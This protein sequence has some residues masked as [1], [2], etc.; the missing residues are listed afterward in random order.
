MGVG[1][2]ARAVK[3]IYVGAGGAPRL[4]WSGNKLANKFRCARITSGV[5]MAC[6]IDPAS[7]ALT[8][9]FSFT[10]YRWFRGSGGGVKYLINRT[11]NNYATITLAKFDPNSFAQIYA[12]PNALPGTPQYWASNLFCEYCQGYL[13]YEGQPT[14][15]IGL[16]RLDEKTMGIAAQLP[17]LINGRPPLLKQARTNSSQLYLQG[18]LDRF[19]RVDGFTGSGPNVCVDIP[20]TMPSGYSNVVAVSDQYIIQTTA[21][22]SNTNYISKWDT[23][24]YA[25]LALNVATSAQP[26]STVSLKK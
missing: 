17:V 13:Y 20:I 16:Y 22:K 19:T 3:E 6:E 24:T 12:F 23:A 25:T 1:G 21:S 11:D 9:L 2:A 4:A 15:W 26:Q 5:Y 18:P 10:E 14:G 8:D 7:L